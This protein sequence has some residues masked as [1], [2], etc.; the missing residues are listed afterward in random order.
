VSRGSTYLLRLRLPDQP[1]S[2]GQVAT[3]LGA[4]GADIQSIVVV[5]RESSYAVDDL[6]V[7]LPD[8]N[9]VDRLVTAAASVPGVVVEMVQRHHGRMDSRDE[10]ALLDAAASHPE[11]LRVLVDGLPGLL[12]A[13][14][15]YAVGPGGYSYGSTSAPSRAPRD[16]LLPLEESREVE[17]EEL[18]ADP[19]VAGPDATLVAVPYAGTHALVL[20]RIGG[21]AFR[22][23]ELMRLAHL[24]NVAAVA[25][26]GL[27]AT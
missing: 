23:S 4:A 16:G 15:A 2:L 5:D 9:L 12:N 18:W 10:L 19:S 26:R 20:G 25:L 7:T 21:P 1:G 8:G 14:Y 3:A 11:P 24:A 6:V 27:A 13:S 22:P 17:A